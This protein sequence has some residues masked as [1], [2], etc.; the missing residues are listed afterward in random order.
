MATQAEIQHT[1]D[2]FYSYICLGHVPGERSTTP[3]ISAHSRLGDLCASAHFRTRVSGL[4]FLF[5]AG[6]GFYTYRCKPLSSY[7]LLAPLIPGVISLWAFYERVQFKRQINDI[8][9]C[10]N[11]MESALRKTLI[12][13]FSGMIRDTISHKI[14]EPAD[15]T[16]AAAH[17]VLADTLTTYFT[18]DSAYVNDLSPE[19]KPLLSRLLEIINAVQTSDIGERFAALML[20]GNFSEQTQLL[21]QCQTISRYLYNL[22]YCYKICTPIYERALVVTHFSDSLASTPML[23]EQPAH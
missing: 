6:L 4:F 2:K 11:Q 16:E 22:R 7:A 20:S 13:K 17:K 15:M 9:G 10:C 19:N 3:V 12:S 5:T 21:K 18:L 8:L 23:H 14:R 1:L